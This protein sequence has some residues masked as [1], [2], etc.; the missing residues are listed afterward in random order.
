MPIS[1]Y[2][3]EL[4]QLV[5]TRLLLMPAVAAIIRD[6]DGNVL[7]LRTPAG[8]WTLP[9]GAV[10]PGESPREAVV[11]E[12][13]EETDLEVTGT[14]LL[15]VFGG[16][17]WRWTYANGDQVEGTVCVFACDVRGTLRCDGEE[18]VEAHWIAAGDVPGLLGLPYPAHLFS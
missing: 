10:D 15:D 14:R 4:R 8:E 6:T 13:R 2:M 17:D 7:V 5:G 12:V 16:V 3:R 11:R 18:I 1:D 9:A